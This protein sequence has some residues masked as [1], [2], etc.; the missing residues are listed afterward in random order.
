[1]RCSSV[2]PDASKKL[3]LTM[4]LDGF[5]F[6]AH[7]SVRNI[8]NW[9]ALDQLESK[10]VAREDGAERELTPEECRTEPGVSQSL[11]VRLYVY[12]VGVNKLLIGTQVVP[13]S[14]S[15]LTDLAAQHEVDVNGPSI[16]HL[17]AR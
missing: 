12:P 17:L 6:P 13:R 7:G 11:C 9:R 3:S 14:W 5:T 2:W 15:V 16:P 8:S 4:K 10:I 1:M